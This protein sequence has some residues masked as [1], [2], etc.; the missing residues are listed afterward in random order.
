MSAKP[1]LI[2]ITPSWEDKRWVLNRTYVSAVRQ[3]GGLPVILP[4]STDPDE[5]ERLVVEIDGLLLTGGSD[6]DPYFYGE[7]PDPRLDMCWPERDRSEIELT[8]R[9]VA[10]GKPL[11]AICRGHQLLNV[12]AGGTLHQELEPAVN[13]I[14]HRQKTVASCVTHSVQLFEGSI[15]RQIA[16]TD[17]LRVNSL[18]HQAVKAVAE[19]F[20]VSAMA[21][22]GVI[23]AIES[24]RH[25]FAVGVQ[26]HPEETADHDDCS[27]Q[28][29]RAFV[30]ACRQEKEEAAP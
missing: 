13:R 4:V 2:G 26:W 14:Q 10:A 3:A 6:V 17:R 30:L 7:E 5:A 21:P 20:R 12:A 25:C 8:R 18:H 9:V 15:L 23:E 29:F 28:L 1:T 19:G 16:Q 22:D 11:L 27:K 24:E